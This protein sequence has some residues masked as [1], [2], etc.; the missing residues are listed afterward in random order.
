MDTSLISTILLFLHLLA[1][2]FGGATSIGMA[3][4]GGLMPTATPEQRQ[5]YFKLGHIF[6]TNGRAALVVLLIT[7]P[8]MIWLKYGG[9]A[10]LS[11]WFSLKMVLVVV[12]IIAVIVSGINFN[13]AEKGD[14]AAAKR[15]SLA[16][17]V[18]GLSLLLIILAATFAFN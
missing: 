14:M 18:G 6:S 2:V 3:A 12:M 10:G 9:G 8:L 5:G 11:W 17:M 1:L 13:R 16:G 4:V 15:A 7:G